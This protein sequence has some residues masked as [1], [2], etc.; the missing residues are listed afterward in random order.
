MTHI[1]K[2]SL[3]KMSIRELEGRLMQ[4]KED[5]KASSAILSKERQKQI[6][7]TK[8]IRGNNLKRKQELIRQIMK[9]NKATAKVQSQIIKIK[10]GNQQSFAQKTLNASVKMQKRKEELKK[11]GTYQTSI[12]DEERVLAYCRD[13]G[14]TEEDL[15]KALEYYTIEELADMPGQEFYDEVHEAKRAGNRNEQMTFDVPEEESL[16]F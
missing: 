12:T 11:F 14:Y 16:D 13:M 8:A 15:Q 9:I 7:K 3:S 10:V 2:E 6:L 1:S 5:F 4:A